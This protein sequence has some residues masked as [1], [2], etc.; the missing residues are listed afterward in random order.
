MNKKED[1]LE[2]IVRFSR[3]SQN[4]VSDPADK[5][6]VA[7]KKR[8]Q[9]F[10][11]AFGDLRH[12]CLVGGLRIDRRRGNF[13]GGECEAG[14]AHYDRRIHRSRDPNSWSIRRSRPLGGP[15]ATSACGF[16]TLISAVLRR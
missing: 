14:Q 5:T 2:Q 4:S 10:L 9:R 1:I 8:S 13:F 3:V 11:A 7:T 12:Q 6:C 16:G 15:A